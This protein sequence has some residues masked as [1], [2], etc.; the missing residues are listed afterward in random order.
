M[1]KRKSSYSRGTARRAVSDTLMME[2]STIMDSTRMA[3]SRPVSYTHLDVYKRQVKKGEV[4]PA[5]GHDY[6]DGKCTHCGGTDPNYKPE[7]PGVKTGDESHLALYL[8][9]LLYTSRCV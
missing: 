6:K 7:Q 4:I 5:T 2:G 1:Y 9:C 3:A 8:A